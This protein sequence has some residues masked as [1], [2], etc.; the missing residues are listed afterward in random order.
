MKIPMLILKLPLLLLLTV[1]HAVLHVLDRFSGI[2]TGVLTL[3]LTGLLIHHWI[4]GSRDNVIPLSLCLGVC[5]GIPAVIQ[6][7]LTLLR[8][9]EERLI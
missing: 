2:C 7:A 6:T 8:Q 3:L 5:L 9:V 1:F 4:Q